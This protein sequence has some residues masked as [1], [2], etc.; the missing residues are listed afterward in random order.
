MGSE[1][2]RAVA[3]DPAL[4]LVAA[5]DG[6]VADIELPADVAAD[7]VARGADPSTMATAGVEVAV[8]FTVADAARRNALWCA[9]NG[10]HAVI[11]TSGLGD[12]DLDELRSAFGAGPAH[13]VVAPNFA[14]G[15]VLLIRLAELAAPWFDTVEVIEMHHDGKADAPSGTAIATA[16]RLA[17]ASSSWAADP[18][19]RE[20]LSGSRGAVGPGGIRIHAVRMR[21]AVAHQ[22][23]LLGTAGQ[24][25]SL[26]HDSYERSSFMPGVLLAIK[27]VAAHPG[28]T[29]GLDTLLGL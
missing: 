16:Q 12:G 4:E 9:A 29:V 13:C 20:N 24:T 27:A 14:I 18:T 2:C 21:G 7:A 1:V 10:V 8:D 19:T 17:A 25:L 11:G 28:V 23:V 26:R 6:R 15:A 22:E 5:V 3:G